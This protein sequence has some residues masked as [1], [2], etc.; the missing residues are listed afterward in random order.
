M[1]PGPSLTMVNYWPGVNKSKER[2]QAMSEKTPNQEGHPIN[3]LLPLL[4]NTLGSKESAR[5]KNH[6]ATCDHCKQEL[7][8]LK[9]V[10]EA[11]KTNKNVFC[12]EPCE[13]YQ[14]IQTG[15][16][17]DQQITSHL[18]ECSLCRQEAEFFKTA[19]AHQKMPA[20][21]WNELKKA[22]PQR[23]SKKAPLKSKFTFLRLPNWSLSFLKIPM[24]ATASAVAILVVALFYPTGQPRLIVALSS[25]NWTHSANAVKLMS[26]RSITAQT[27]TGAAASPKV[28]RPRV[29][30]IIFLDE[31]SSRVNQEKIDL[32]YRFLQPSE[33]V[34]NMFEFASPQLLKELICQGKIKTGETHELIDGLRH[35]LNIDQAILIRI[36][37]RDNKFDVESDLFDTRTGELLR[38]QTETGINKEQLPLRLQDFSIFPG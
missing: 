24:L 28:S 2:G 22:F 12:P 9:N 20:Q 32:L 11:L 14:F 13:I 38:Q 25:Q 36:L 30:I 3:L 8:S 1:N 17:P 29:A 6:E 26:P 21:M 15:R 23:D 33:A 5:V 7:K 16:D 34:K 27:G 4:K 18:N 31:R 10:A 37:E 35:A 19:P